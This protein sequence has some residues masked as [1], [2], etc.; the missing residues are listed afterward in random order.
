V[1]VREDLRR[2]KA[3]MEAGEIPVS[4]NPG[5]GKP[6]KTTFDAQVNLGQTG[7]DVRGLQQQA[8]SDAHQAVHRPMP[9][10]EARGGNTTFTPK[11]PSEAR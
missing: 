3:L 10:D 6:P 2:Y 4:Y 9:G 1:Q 8:A 5:Q 11:N 7:G